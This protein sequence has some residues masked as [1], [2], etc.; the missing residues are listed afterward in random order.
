MLTFLILLLL[1]AIAAGVALCYYKIKRVHLKAFE[2]AQRANERL[3]NLYTQLET[4]MALYHD[5]KPAV[6]FPGTRGWAGSPDFLRHVAR[7][8]ATHK[9]EFIV[10]CSSGTSTVVLARTAQMNGVGHVY[11]LEHEPLYAQKT[12]NELARQGLSAF[13]TVLDAPLREHQL[14]GNTHRWYDISGLPAKIDL[15][16]IDGPPKDTQVQARY[17]AVPVLLSK[18]SPQARVMLDDADRPDE[19]AAVARWQSES[20]LAVDQQLFAEKGIAML[21]RG[22]A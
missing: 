8:A 15:L 5:L 20:G 1:L 9:P 22:T 7:A 17:P 6:G 19:R 14:G 3:D 12:R 18:L 13:A 2:D 21:R 4:L 11:S 16:V 10:E